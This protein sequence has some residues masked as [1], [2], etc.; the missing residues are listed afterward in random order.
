MRALISHKNNHVNA[1]TKYTRTFFYSVPYLRLSPYEKNSPNIPMY[2]VHFL[3]LY[4]FEA[5][6]SDYSGNRSIVVIGII[7]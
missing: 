4:V 3:L 7:D 6:C 1:V 2:H 5:A